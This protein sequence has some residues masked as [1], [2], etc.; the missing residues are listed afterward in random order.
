[1]GAMMTLVSQEEGGTDMLGDK[2]GGLR[3]PD[4]GRPPRSCEGLGLYLGADGKPPQRFQSWQY[5][6]RFAFG[7]NSLVAT[8]NMEEGDKTRG[9][10][11]MK[12]TQKREAE[13]LNHPDVGVAGRGRERGCKKP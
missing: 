8:R 7:I 2:L 4:C 13:W 3:G 10:R 12:N 6:M 11:P 5:V 1:M 9:W